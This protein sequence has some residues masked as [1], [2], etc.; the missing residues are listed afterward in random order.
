[1]GIVRPDL[2]FVLGSCKRKTEENKQDGTE[3]AHV[4]KIIKIGALSK[5][6]GY[7]AS[8]FNKV[9]MRLTGIAF[10]EMD[11]T[12]SGNAPIFLLS[13]KEVSTWM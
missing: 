12:E 7:G 5:S 13:P 11:L 10:L 6:I 8:S 2:L 3:N 9:N 1:L 4:R